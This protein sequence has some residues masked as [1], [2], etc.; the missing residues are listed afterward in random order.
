MH[1]SSLFISKP[2]AEMKEREDEDMVK[3]KDCFSEISLWQLGTM[4]AN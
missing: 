1:E 4:T 2:K 3:V